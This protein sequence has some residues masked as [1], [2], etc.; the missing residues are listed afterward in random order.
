M[1]IT[2]TDLAKEKLTGL[3]ANKTFGLSIVDGCCG[4]SF[5]LDPNPQ[6]DETRRFI[7]IDDVKFYIDDETERI[8]PE[9]S[10]DYP[11]PIDGFMIANLKAQGG[12]ACGRSFFVDEQ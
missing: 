4:K 12:C 11:G 2:V 5:A 1:I 6:G 3:S 9:V 10:I 7:E 8:A